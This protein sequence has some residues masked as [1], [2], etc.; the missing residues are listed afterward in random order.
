MKSAQGQHMG[1]ARRREFLSCGLV[2]VS[3]VAQQK[4]GHH[5]PG[6]G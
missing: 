3:A 2:D 6:M 1:N 4:G 5:T